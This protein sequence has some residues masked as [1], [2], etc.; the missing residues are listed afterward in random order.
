MIDL[1]HFAKSLDGKPVALFGLG[2]S[3]LA[4]VN[5]LLATGIKVFAWDDNEA[6]RA[7]VQKTDAICQPLDVETLSGCAC[8]ILAPGV[9]L[10][11]PEPHDVV[12]AAHE[13]GIEIIGDVEVLYRCDHGHKTIG[14]TGTN[15]KSTTTAL[16]THVLNACGHDAVMGGNIGVPV[17]QMSPNTKD[18]IFVLEM[19]SYQI[20]LCPTFHPDIGVL[21]NITPDHIDRHGSFKNYAA[22]KNRMLNG[23][24]IAIRENDIKQQQKTLD[25]EKF[26]VLPGD[27][28]KENIAAVLEVCARVDITREAALDAVRTFPGLPHRQFLVR[29][30]NGIGYVNDSKGTNAEATSKA[31][32]AYKNI[33]WIVGGQ[34][35][36]GGLKGLEIYKDR[37]HHA[38]LIGDAAQ[39][40]AH[41]MDRHHIPYDICGTLDVA[42]AQAHDMAQAHKGQPGGGVVLLSPAC[43]S[44][45][46]FK[47]FE[48]RGDEFVK[49]VEGLDA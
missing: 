9:P 48:H 37:I 22:I 43:A 18:T 33:F 47:S 7:A 17:L 35:K 10:T 32:S 5:A 36:D 19:S 15:G 14:I 30:I 2:L 29:T 4:S 46:Q 11:H 12:K 6:S 42:I 39:D 3:G 8:L 21:L 44:F 45:D 1:S 27:H 38:F 34:A 25:D 20:D 16:L 49:Y 40:F 13:A 41:W 24:G 23:A 31:L 26:P 28:N